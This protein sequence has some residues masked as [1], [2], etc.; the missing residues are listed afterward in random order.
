MCN[1]YIV[2]VGL[3][4]LLY[5]GGTIDMTQLL[6]LLALLSTTANLNSLNNSSSATNSR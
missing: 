6:L 3:L 1:D 4:F 2:F 5:S